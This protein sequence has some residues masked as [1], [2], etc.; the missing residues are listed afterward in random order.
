MLTYKRKL[1][2]NKA[3]KERIDSWMNTCRF[4]YNMALEIRIAAW[5]K[6]LFK[7]LNP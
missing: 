2:L 5:R 4:V 6:E 1:I 3:Q 7:T